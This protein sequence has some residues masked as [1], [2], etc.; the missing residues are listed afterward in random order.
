MN[1]WGWCLQVLEARA[2][3]GAAYADLRNYR[4]PAVILDLILILWVV[5]KSLVPFSVVQHIILF[6]Y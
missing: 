6:L 2:E 1:G 3:Q 5:V 4:F